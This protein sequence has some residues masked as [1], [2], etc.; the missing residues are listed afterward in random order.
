[1]SQRHETRPFIVIWETTQACDLA[2]LHCRASAKSERDRRELGTDE[3]KELLASFAR[4]GVPLVVLTGGDPAKR[5]DLVELV[6]YGKSLG[7]VMALTPS[8][9]PLV[10]PE[11]LSALAVAGLS[12]IAISIDGA[13]AETHD[14]FRGVEGSFAHSLRI[15]GH[16][17][18][19]GM[20]T[21]INTS[22]HLSSTRAL[23]SIARI[24][25]DMGCVLWSVFYLVPTGRARASMLPSAEE[26]EKSLRVLF[27]ISE[28]A[29]FGVKT[30]AAPH[31]RRVIIQRKK[32]VRG[33]AAIRINDG[34]GFLFVSHTGDVFPSGFLPL[35]CG[36]VRESDPIEIYRNHPVFVALRD[37]E[38]LRGKCG[39]CEFKDLCG[40]S[41][42]RAL[43]MTGDYLGSDPLCAYIPKGWNEPTKRHLGVIHG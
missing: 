31:Y 25:E 33:R 42:A 26:V 1:M 30:T 19:L 5:P 11:L 29:P 17:K 37:P 2:C 28:Q 13:D 10:T 32:E 41:R 40:G 23:P 12:R 20:S 36:N 6:A 21:Q 3:A 22:V 39:A 43:A 14:R 16:A 9:T 4:A 34:R 35:P 8:A 38:Q 7:L 15:L 27:E 24:V 18:S